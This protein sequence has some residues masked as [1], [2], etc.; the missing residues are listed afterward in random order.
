M[1]ILLT[2]LSLQDLLRRLTVLNLLV[3]LVRCQALF[4]NGVRRGA[5]D[6]CFD[7]AHACSGMC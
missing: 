3:L 4:R 6:A 1:L 7:G 2:L 5:L